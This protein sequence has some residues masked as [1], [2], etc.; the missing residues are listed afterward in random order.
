MILPPATLGLL[1]GGQLGSMFTIAART[2]GYRVVVLDP[3]PL[4]PAAR[5]ADEHVCAPFDDV[6]ALETLARRCAAVTTEFENIPAAS[7]R[8]LES[9][10]R[11][12]PSANAVEICQSR[13]REKKFLR[14]HGF[15]TASFEMLG[16]SDD[17]AAV[18]ERIGSPAILKTSRFGYDGKGQARID[19]AVALRAA[20]RELNAEEYVLEQRIDLEMEI[21]VV[22][23]RSED[24]AVQMYPVAE[25]IH[26]DGILD[27][28]I[29]PARVSPRIGAE[30]AMLAQRIAEKLDY[31]GVM[32]VEFFLARGGA[33]LVNE[34]APR[35]HNS[36]HYTLDA[37]RTSQFEQQV[38]TLCQL[39]LGEASQ[40]TP[41]VMLNLLGNIWMHGEPAWHH[42]L[43]AEGKLHL[44]GKAEARP[45]RKMGH[46]TFINADLDAALQSA[47]DA[48][49]GLGF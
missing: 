8:Q 4:S 17:A 19:D 40:H 48:R 36:G 31:C 22:I 38:R 21:S 32:A 37:C 14:M 30:A 7:L 39:P 12:S 24:G 45:G 18:L 5:F 15:P 1:G 13:G 34:L 28:T 44:Y 11:V 27:T 43:T 26:R 35:P 16:D 6:P 10:T 23:A 29:V 20:M 49:R 33:L 47:S 41:A 2:M 25:N 3:D 9:K 42:A 46:C